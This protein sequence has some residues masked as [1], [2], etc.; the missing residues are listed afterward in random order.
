M[1]LCFGPVGDWLAS[2]DNVSEF[3]FHAA[4]SAATTFFGVTMSDTRTITLTGRRPVK[5]EGSD[6]PLIASASD[7]EYDNEHEF[8]A[9][10]ISKWFVGVR[11]HDDCRAIVYASYSYTSNWANAR[12]YA[13]KRGVLL[14]AGSSDDDINLAIREVCNDIASAEHCGDDASRWDGLMHECVADMPAESL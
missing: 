10:Q 5:I 1:R 7:K 14:P 12:G 11:Q 9:N 6:W 3:R 8:Q 4:R 2:V 13:A